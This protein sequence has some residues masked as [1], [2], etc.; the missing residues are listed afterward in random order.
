MQVIGVGAQTPAPSHLGYTLAGALVGGSSFNFKRLLLS[1]RVF[2]GGRKIIGVVSR[3]RCH[4][5]SCSNNI[6]CACFFSSLLPVL[7]SNWNII[8]VISSLCLHI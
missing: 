6:L 8:P 7:N 3:C 2:A 4:F 1:A 5:Y